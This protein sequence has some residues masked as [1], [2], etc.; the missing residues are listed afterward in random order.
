MTT[1]EIVSLITTTIASNFTSLLAVIAVGA[2]IKIVLDVVFKSLYSIT[3]S[4]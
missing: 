3:N 1:Q 4:R 2:G